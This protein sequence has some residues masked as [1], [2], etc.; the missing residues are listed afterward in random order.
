MWGGGGLGDKRAQDWVCKVD[1]TKVCLE[2]QHA[3]LL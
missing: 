3:S 1:I 2:L